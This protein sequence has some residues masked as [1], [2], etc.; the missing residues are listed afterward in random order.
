MLPRNFALAQ[1]QSRILGVTIL[2]RP[3]TIS[4]HQNTW[5]I[6]NTRDL[7]WT[8]SGTVGLVP[9]SVEIRKSQDYDS[10]TA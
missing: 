2:Q 7:G 1:L 9:I 8:N 6:E 10:D 3:T 4:A 5:Q